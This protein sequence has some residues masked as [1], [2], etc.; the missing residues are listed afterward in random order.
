MVGLLAENPRVGGG[1]GR[2]FSEAVVS[3]GPHL[4]KHAGS[5][6]LGPQVLGLEALNGLPSPRTCGQ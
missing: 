2:G 5:S 6:T 4:R 3:S 1:Q